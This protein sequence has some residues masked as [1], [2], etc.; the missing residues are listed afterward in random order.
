MTSPLS[1]YLWRIRAFLWGFFYCCAT[2]EEHQ[3][4]AEWAARKE[5]NHD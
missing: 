5:L 3:R 2:D 1:W 4:R